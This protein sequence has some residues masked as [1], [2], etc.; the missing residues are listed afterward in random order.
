MTT[1]TTLSTYTSYLISSRDMSAS[2]D[3][4]AS[5]GEVKTDTQYYKDNIGNVKSADDLVGNYRLYSYAMEAYGLSDMTYAKAFMKKVLDSDLSD[6]NSFANKLTDKRYAAFAAAF[7]FNN[8]SATAQ[9]SV[10]EDNTVTAY[11]DSFDQEE[12]N[13]ETANSDYA[14]Q[15]SSVSSVSDLLSDSDLKTYVLNAYGM[16]PT[17]TSSS[18][19]QQVL[20]S[21]P[22]DPDS[23]ANQ[24][25]NANAIA[26]A[27]AFNFQSDGTV[28]D[29]ETAQTSDQ[30]SAT[31][32]EYIYNVSTYPSD[33]LGQSNQAYWDSKISTITNVDDLVNDPRMV[34]Y[35]STAYGIDTQ[36]TSTVKSILT[37][38]QSA[39]IMGFTNVK[40]LFNFNS[41]GT[42]PDGETAQ[43]T[44]QTASVDSQYS[45]T[46]QKNQQSTE[47]DAVTNYKDQIGDIKTVDDFL[48]SSTDDSDSTTS[49]STTEIWQVALRAYGID[50]SSV[51]TSDLKKILTSDVDNP[52]S[53]VNELDDARYVD[54]VKAFNFDSD[55]DI[56]APLLAQSDS[57]SSTITS[58]YLTQETKF[59][60]GTDLS[61]AKTKAQTEIDYYN[62][63]MQTITTSSQLLSD[64]RLTNVLLTSYGI[65]PKSVSSSDLKKMFASDLDDPKSFVNQEDNPAFA[66]MVAS[67]NFDK[68]G[69]LTS[70]ALGGV[71]QR[72]Q[73]LTTVDNY[74]QQSLEEQ[75]GDTN[76]GVRL[77]LYFKREAP[78]ITSSYNI[79][80]DTALFSFFKTAFSLPDN[81]S[82]MDTDK[83]ADMVE[84]YIDFSKLSDSDYVDSLIQKF[85]ALYDEANSTATSPALTILQ[86]SGSSSTGMTTPI[87]ISQDSLLAIANLS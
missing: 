12:T 42:I 63:Q 26:M 36:F 75:E 57:V 60:T 64:S 62:K 66:E 85:S 73:V 19:L 6:S 17:Y 38:D 28:A 82:N 20:T 70:D 46:F 31:Q 52:T 84:K 41:D 83:Q 56:K 2:L 27:K 18:W 50:P 53:Y 22:D 13:I 54:L 40:A 71:Q 16:D 61:T 79:L 86:N 81:I 39:D 3:R 45:S 24:T 87:S 37:S 7:N 67:F 10:Q 30:V 5:Q 80:S 74:M 68:K 55:G 23:F 49:S 48:K 77:A 14:D 44:E 47:D 4:I 78:D 11:Q 15:I 25:G 34:D 51:D 35:L 8:T 33:L 43:S 59:L 58:D 1:S 21:D 29:G 72:G 76:E 9:T 69:E 65:D 32:S